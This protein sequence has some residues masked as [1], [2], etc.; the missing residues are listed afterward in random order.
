MLKTEALLTTAEVAERL[1]VSTSFLAKA[2][3]TGLGPT[4]IEVGRAR[5]Q[6]AL[7]RSL[8]GFA[9]CSHRA[10]GGCTLVRKLDL[11]TPLLEKALLIEPNS[12]WAWQRSGW[13]KS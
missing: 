13:L 8:S 4:F 7:A 2:R 5:A 1:R 11:A 12:T 3:V 9:T 6:G 10:H